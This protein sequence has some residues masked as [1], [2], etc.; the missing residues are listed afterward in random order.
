MGCVRSRIEAGKA[1]R[2]RGDSSLDGDTVR[3]WG[4]CNDDFNTFTRLPGTFCRLALGEILL[5][6]R[7]STSD[8]CILQETSQHVSLM[9]RGPSNKTQTRILHWMR[10]GPELGVYLLWTSV[11]KGRKVGVEFLWQEKRR[12][13]LRKSVLNKFLVP[14][15][16]S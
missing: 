10:T 16:V 4:G 8:T 6:E 14:Q 1:T 5:L 7:G 15:I 11:D 13:S 3:R 9:A 12:S 2:F